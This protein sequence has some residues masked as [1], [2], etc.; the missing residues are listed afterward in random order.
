MMRM[1]DQLVFRSEEEYN[2]YV[3]RELEES[4]RE[5]ADP[6]TRWIPWRESVREGD[7]FLR[8]LERRRAAK[9]A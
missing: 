3:L 1:Q 4:E 5:A 7:A 6:N 9:S 8:E 2:A